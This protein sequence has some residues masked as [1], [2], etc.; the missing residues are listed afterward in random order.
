MF[1]NLLFA[2]CNRTILILD[3][4]NIRMDL[5]FETPGIP[6]RGK[7]VKVAEVPSTLVVPDNPNPASE[8]ADGNIYGYDVFL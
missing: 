5:E 8:G 7:V 1:E 6:G 4:A 2:L 3:L